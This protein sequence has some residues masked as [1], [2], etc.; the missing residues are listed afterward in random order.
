MVT[1]YLSHIVEKLSI[2]EHKWIW[3]LKVTTSN[4]PKKADEKRFEIYDLSAFINRL[5]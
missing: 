3:Q 5:D 2:L 1:W 4:A